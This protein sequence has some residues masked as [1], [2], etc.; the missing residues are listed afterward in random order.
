MENLTDCKRC[1]SN[2]CLI[3]ELEETVTGYLCFGCGFTTS[4]VVLENSELDQHIYN[5]SPELYKDLRFIDKDGMVWYPAGIT[6]DNQ[7]V[8]FLDGTSIQDYKW[9]GALMSP[10]TEE[11]R[12]KFPKETT[13]KV[14]FGKAKH[15]DRNDFMEA[16]DYIGFFKHIQEKI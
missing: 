10:L 11:E 5:K 2:A 6:L 8:V 7:G 12:H 1:G 15:F 3:Q 16:L 4:T 9:T 14:D 13:H